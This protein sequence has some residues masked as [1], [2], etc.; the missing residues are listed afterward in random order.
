MAKA[1]T[2]HAPLELGTAAFWT[3]LTKE[4]AALAAQICAIDLVDLD[5][6]LQQHASL[7]AW[8]NA[9]Y[10]VARIGEEKLKWEL[11]KTR[12]SLTYS[13]SRV[14][15]PV[16]D[17]PKTIA[18]LNAEVD[19]D[20]LVENVTKRLHTQGEMR[21]AL[22]AM[23]KGLEDRKDMLIQIAAKQRREIEDYR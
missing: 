23:T 3:R 12:A 6:T 18:V 10:E 5:T 19:N 8:V 17:K 13:A 11:T 2:T 16:T 22:G 14:N 20:P 4:P 21:A 1:K 15:D 9:S 7:R